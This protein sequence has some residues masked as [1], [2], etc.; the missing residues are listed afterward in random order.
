MTEGQ[1]DSTPWSRIDLD[2]RGVRDKTE[3]MDRLTVALDLPTWFGRN[4]DA[5]ADCLRE[6]R[7]EPGVE[8]VWRGEQ[9]LPEGLRE[10]LHDVLDERAE[11]G[12]TPWRTIRVEE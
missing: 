12:P 9:D 4:W 7:G 8:F 10:T 2:T 6:V 5:L 3:L 1:P 11:A